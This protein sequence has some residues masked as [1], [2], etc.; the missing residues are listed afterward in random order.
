MNKTKV[1]F[2][3]QTLNESFVKNNNAHVDPNFI[4]EKL[5]NLY[6]NFGPSIHKFSFQPVTEQEVVKATKTLKSM[7][8]GVDQINSFVI[9]S[10]LPRISTVLVHLVKLSFQCHIF[11]EN[12][13]KGSYNSNTKRINTFIS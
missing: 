12:S 13:K 2:P 1:N 10:L 4:E 6:K 8:L 5:K 9:K 7:A 3:A 11:P